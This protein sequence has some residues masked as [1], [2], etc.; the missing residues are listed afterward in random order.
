MTG[1]IIG[2]L[3]AIVLLCGC[4]RMP[5]NPIQGNAIIDWVDFLKLN[6]K[7]YTG[8]WE[9]VLKDP[10]DVTDE[11]VGEV[12]FKV[13][14]VVTNPGYRTKDGDA[15]F[16]E[17]GTKLYRVK[18]FEPDELLA[19]KDDEKIGGFR[20]Y[21]E[22]E[23]SKKLHSRYEDIS[24]GGV[25]R[26]ELYGLDAVTPYKTLVDGDKE[27]FIQ[28]LDNGKDTPGYSSP[29]RER[30]PDY[31]RMVFYMDGPIAY[32]FTIAD[33]GTN[34]FFSPWETRLVDTEI[35]TLLQE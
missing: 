10:L 20:I 31:R 14:D 3:A 8:L 9:G 4:S 33:D 5:S 35:R 6:G 29:N 2:L 7:S 11:V 34:V 16:M 1:R 15:A 24:K 27:R 25:E 30:D 17:K 12:E 28:L 21:A 19:A 26:I 23:F 22:D 13:A 18:G 32:S